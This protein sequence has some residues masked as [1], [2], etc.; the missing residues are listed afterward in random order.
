[1]TAWAIILLA[2]IVALVLGIIMA[3]GA[4]IRDR[5]LTESAQNFLAESNLLLDEN[6]AKVRRMPKAELGAGIRDLLEEGQRD[7]AI[8]I[9]RK[10]TGVDQYTARDAIDALARE[11][12]LSDDGPVQGD[13]AYDEDDLDAKR[14][15]Q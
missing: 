15:V 8:E 5:S 13:G 12:K 6:E 14:E 2:V 7:E 3:Q 10:F 9:Y 4:K 1:M 11:M